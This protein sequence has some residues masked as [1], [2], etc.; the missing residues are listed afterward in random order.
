MTNRSGL[1]LVSN[2]A[3][4]APIIH[5]KSLIIL[6]L[7]TSQGIWISEGLLYKIKSECANLDAA[8]VFYGYSI[9][10]LI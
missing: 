5:K 9:H 6:L 10:K 4:H 1:T 2:E 8:T 3:A 7:V